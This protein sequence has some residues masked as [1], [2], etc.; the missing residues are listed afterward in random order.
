MLFIACCLFEAR[1]I[2]SMMNKRASENTEAFLVNIGSKF[3]YNILVVNE[4]QVKLRLW[5]EQVKR[6]KILSLQVQVP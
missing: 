3:C 4:T 6:G 5:I 1:A 2:G